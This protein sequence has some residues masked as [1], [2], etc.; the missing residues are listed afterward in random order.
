VVAVLAERFPVRVKIPVI[1]GR[2]IRSISQLEGIL[3][4]FPAIYQVTDFDEL[5]LDAKRHLQILEV[6]KD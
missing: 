6:V 3:Q 2:E 5:L 4:E 1:H